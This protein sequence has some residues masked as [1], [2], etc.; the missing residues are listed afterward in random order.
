MYVHQTHFTVAH[1]AWTLIAPLEEKKKGKR[2]LRPIAVVNKNG[3][4]SLVQ[5]IWISQHFDQVYTYVVHPLACTAAN[6]ALRSGYYNI[7]AMGVG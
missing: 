3:G 7:L 2:K 4:D 5:D 6:A 1:Q